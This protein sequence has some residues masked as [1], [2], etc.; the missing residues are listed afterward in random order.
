M[1]WKPLVKSDL[2][3]CSGYDQQEPDKIWMGIQSRERKD[4]EEKKEIP[5]CER[6]PVTCIASA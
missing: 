1:R 3:E 2:V 6:L 5:T 4:E